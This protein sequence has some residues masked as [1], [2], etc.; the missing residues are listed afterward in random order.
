MEAKPSGNAHRE[1]F[2]GWQVAGIAEA[3]E[4]G[5]RKVLFWATPLHFVVK[6]ICCG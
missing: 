6:A 5:R 2:S 3:I 1:L 4:A